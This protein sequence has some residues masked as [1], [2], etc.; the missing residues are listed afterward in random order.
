MEDAE[1]DARV[2]NAL[3]AAAWHGQAAVSRLPIFLRRPIHRARGRAALPGLRCCGHQDGAAPRWR[4]PR[5]LDLDCSTGAAV[6]SVTAGSAPAS[7]S[8]QTQY[9]LHGNASL[10][11][12]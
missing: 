7:G 3:G 5:T 10:Q 12:P 1:A 4:N 11:Q 8:V 2:I 6:G 9:A